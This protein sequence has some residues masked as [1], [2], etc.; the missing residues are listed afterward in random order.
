MDLFFVRKI[1][2]RAKKVA[3]KKKKFA[4]FHRFDP[5]DISR[6]VPYFPSKFSFYLPPLTRRWN[7][8]MANNRNSTSA[9]QLRYAFLQD[10]VLPLFVP[11]Y[12]PRRGNILR[13]FS[14]VHGALLSSF[15]PV[16]D[17]RFRSCFDRHRSPC[18]NRK[19]ALKSSNAMKRWVIE[20]STD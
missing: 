8:E 7:I 1:I 6:V 18:G 11:T 3:F 10:Q 15:R 17:R 20:F 19:T 9:R 12:L 2:I 16:K 5:I 14:P 4:I 13:D